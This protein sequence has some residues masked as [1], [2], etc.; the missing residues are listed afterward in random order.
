[1]FFENEHLSFNILEVSYLAQKKV[2]MFNS[3]RDFSALSYRVHAD[4]VL[5]SS[6]SEHRLTD[7]SVVFVPSGVDYSRVAN[8]DEMI[9]IRLDSISYSG[10]DIES[11]IP[12]DPNVLAA[13]FHR[14]MDCWKNKELGY[15]YRC[16]AIM[17]EILAECYLENYVS[18]PVKSA[19][20]RSV[21]FM[22]SSYTSRDLSIGEIA[23]K[24]FMSEVYFRR[25]FKKE[26]GISPQKYIVD[27]RIK[28]AAGLISTGYYS[29]AEVASMSGYTDYKYFSSEFKRLMGVSPSEYS[30]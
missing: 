6:S 17:Y 19:I 1:M 27:L 12:R 7:N 16:S 21:D 26:Y 14:I 9:V 24:S 28:H 20:G 25:I 8:V 18:K 30:K 11:F 5:R 2:N 4:T 23:A 22:L 3:G 15:K 13:L 10:N 29:L